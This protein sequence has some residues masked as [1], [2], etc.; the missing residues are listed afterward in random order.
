ML[1]EKDAGASC[2]CVAVD[3]GNHQR[4]PVF[5]QRRN[6]GN[7][8]VQF[9]GRILFAGPANPFFR[10]FSDTPA[11]VRYPAVSR[12]IWSCDRPNPVTPPSPRRHAGLGRVPTPSCDPA[13]SRAFG[14]ATP[15]ERDEAPTPDG[16]GAS[17]PGWQVKDSNLRRQSRRIYSPLPLAARATCLGCDSAVPRV[18]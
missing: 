4:P 13:L 9:V 6:P 11:R 2:T 17:F 10:F 14:G 18:A 8:I 1:T 5:C 15:P 3:C 12:P 16:V 7:A